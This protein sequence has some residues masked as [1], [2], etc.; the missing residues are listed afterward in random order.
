LHFLYFIPEYTNV[1]ILK[2]LNLGRNAPSYTVTLQPETFRRMNDTNDNI[3]LFDGVC[4]LCNRV[5]QFTIIRDPKRKFKFASLQSDAGQ[6]ILKKFGLSIS[7]FE[8]FVLIKGDN[9]Y[10]K[11]TA[12]LMVLRELGGFWGL[13]YFLMIVPRPVRDFL[14][15]LI[16]KSRYRIFGRRATCMVPTPDLADRFL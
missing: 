12:A 2:E 15:N 8:S 4:N 14:Y 13:F 10:L 3:L 6:Q 11:S 5:I 7:D 1:E 9:Y 16:A